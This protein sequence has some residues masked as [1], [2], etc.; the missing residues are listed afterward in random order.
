MAGEEGDPGAF[1]GEIDRVAVVGVGNDREMLRVG[2]TAVQECL[3]TG[4]QFVKAMLRHPLVDVT[5]PDRIAGRGFVDNVL[6]LG[7]PTGERAGGDREGIGC[8]EST[9]ATGGGVLEQG[10]VIQV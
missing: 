2:G 3:D 1:G 10:A 7:G 6:V 9:L 4:N 5:P 8:G